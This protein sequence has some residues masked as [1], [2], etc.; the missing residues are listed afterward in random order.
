MQKLR[1]RAINPT[2]EQTRSEAA[3]DASGLR[4]GCFIESE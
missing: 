1:L 4:E 2:F 3:C